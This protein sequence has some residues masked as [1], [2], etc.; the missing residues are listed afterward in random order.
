[1]LAT[2]DKDPLAGLCSPSLLGS[3]GVMPLVI[4][5]ALHDIARH[6]ANLI[7]RAEKDVFLATNY[8]KASE[9]SE[10]ICNG[11][12]ELS[13]RMGEKGRKAVVK[14]LYDRGA[15]KQVSL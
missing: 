2:L 11:I 14:V 13:K 10:I 7:V 6:M 1:M 4:I 9:A 5:S 15:L 3:S 12:R 8:W